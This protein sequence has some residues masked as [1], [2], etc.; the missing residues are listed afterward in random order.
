MNDFFS[1]CWHDGDIEKIQISSNQINIVVLLDDCVS[2]VT[3]ACHDTV[4]LTNL[5]M[6]EDTIISKATLERVG[7]NLSPFLQEI[8][9]AHRLVGEIYGNRPIRN[10][11]L[12][13]SIKLVNDVTFR[14]YCYNVEII[15]E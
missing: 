5:C 8:K 11:L 9:N 6:W 14:I 3:I 7:D 10:D 13:L 4:G 1:Y 12:C 2:P 15:S